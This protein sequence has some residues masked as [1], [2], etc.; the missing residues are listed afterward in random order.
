MKTNRK[1]PTGFILTD[2]K[3]GIMRRFKDKTIFKMPMSE[4][5]QRVHIAQEVLDY[6][7]AL[8]YVKGAA[9]EHGL[10]LKLVWK[11]RNSLSDRIQKVF[12]LII[13]KTQLR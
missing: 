3:G 6:H 2:G 1:Q 9:K 4:P 13:H 8:S 11:E 12:Q 5:L 7:S 10:R